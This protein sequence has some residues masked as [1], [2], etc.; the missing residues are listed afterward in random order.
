MKTHYTRRVDRV[1]FRA[2]TLARSGNH[3]DC[4]AVE[5]ALEQEGFDTPQQALRDPFVREHL[6]DLCDRGRSSAPH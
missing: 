5:R 6:K 3:A 4:A 1:R 2:Y